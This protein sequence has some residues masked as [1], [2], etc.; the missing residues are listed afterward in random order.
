MNSIR[1][2]AFLH[3]FTPQVSRRYV[4]AASDLSAHLSR[5]I[6]FIKQSLAPQK[7]PL[8]D[9][10]RESWLR[11]QRAVSRCKLPCTPR[12]PVHRLCGGRRR[13]ACRELEGSA[14]TGTEVSSP[15]VWPQGAR[16]TQG[17]RFSAGIGSL[18]AR[19]SRKIP[20][21][22]RQHRQ[23]LLSGSEQSPAR[24]TCPACFSLLGPMSA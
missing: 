14:G 18:Q 6:S 2:N 7:C 5:P 12:P 1:V 3:T 16:G 21:I 20:E 19:E 23:E 4:K 10:S 17:P 9:L 13:G 8:K 24:V 15:A 11:Q 22:S